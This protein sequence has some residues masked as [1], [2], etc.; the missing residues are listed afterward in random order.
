MKQLNTNF[1]VSPA[2]SSEDSCVPS[3][4]FV[5]CMDFEAFA[6]NALFYFMKFGALGCREM[7]Y[8]T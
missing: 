6:F 7:G 4:L 1:L 3:V 2:F 8:C 5:F